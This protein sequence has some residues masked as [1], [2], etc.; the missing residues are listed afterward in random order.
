MGPSDYDDWVLTQKGGRIEKAMA[1]GN[2]L[3]AYTPYVQ[4]MTCHWLPRG[5]DNMIMSEQV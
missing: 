2:A 4:C 5:R 1:T 3:S